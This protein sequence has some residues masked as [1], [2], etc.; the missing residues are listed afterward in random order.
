[1]ATLPDSRQRRGK[2]FIVVN[3]N[4]GVPEV[5]A[6]LRD[7]IQTIVGDMQSQAGADAAPPAK[8]KK[9]K[10]RKAEQRSPQ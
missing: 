5:F 6:D 1:M 3:A 7:A 2:L 4:R 10:K 9:K 8:P